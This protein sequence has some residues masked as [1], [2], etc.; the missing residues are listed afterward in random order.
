MPLSNALESYRKGR[1]FRTKEAVAAFLKQ[2]SVFS[3]R[4]PIYFDEVENAN[5]WSF[6]LV[7]RDLH[8]TF[9]EYVVA[10]HLPAYANWSRQLHLLGPTI[11]RGTFPIAETASHFFRPVPEAGHVMHY[12]LEVLDLSDTSAVFGFAGFC[13]RGGQPPDQASVFALWLRV[14]VEY[15]GSERV[16]APLPLPVTTVLRADMARPWGFL[17]RPVTS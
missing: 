15:R 13:E 1:T 16:R 11:E 6:Y 10:R 4:K 17:E 3:R 5:V 14:F 8:H 9:E 12:A 2:P 7:D